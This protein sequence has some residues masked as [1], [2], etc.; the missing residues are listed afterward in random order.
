M[1]N[2]F[3]WFD[4]VTSEVVEDPTGAVLAPWQPRA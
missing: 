2:P 3:V 4:L 1:E